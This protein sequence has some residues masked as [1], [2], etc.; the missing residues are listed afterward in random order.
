[1]NIDA[2]LPTFWGNQTIIFLQ[3][4]NFGTTLF[5]PSKVVFILFIISTLFKH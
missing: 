5:C 2:G 1:M 4:L 3:I